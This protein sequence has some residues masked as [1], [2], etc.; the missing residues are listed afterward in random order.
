MLHARF[1]TLCPI[2]T[3]HEIGKDRRT[4]D[5]EAPPRARKVSL[6]APASQGGW[7]RKRIRVQRRFQVRS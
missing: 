3:T 6:A 2:V 5:G 4:D 7:S 1:R